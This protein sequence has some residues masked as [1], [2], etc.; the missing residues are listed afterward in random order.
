LS[1]RFAALR[2]C[3]VVDQF[4]HPA[5]TGKYRVRYWFK[6]HPPLIKPNK[7]TPP[8]LEG[9]LVL[10]GSVPFVLERE[11]VEHDGRHFAATKTL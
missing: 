9:R 7:S 10:P 8:S 6:P 1:G 2:L 4:Q 5:F 11:S 3:A